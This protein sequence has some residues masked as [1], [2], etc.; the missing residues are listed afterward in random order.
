MFL[1][2]KNPSLPNPSKGGAFNKERDV[3][4]GI[5]LRIILINL[6]FALH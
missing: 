6:Q 2:I 1:C 5:N 4:G 3:E